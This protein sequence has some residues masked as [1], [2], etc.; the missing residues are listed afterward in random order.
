MTDDFSGF[1]VLTIAA[2]GDARERDVWRDAAAIPASVMID[3]L[4]LEEERWQQLADFFEAQWKSLKEAFVAA[5]KHDK[6]IEYLSLKELLPIRCTP[7]DD[8]LAGPI[9][10]SGTIIARSYAH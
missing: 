10:A 8:S 3:G 9:A 6:F 4:E 1:S 7:P 5:R 2:H